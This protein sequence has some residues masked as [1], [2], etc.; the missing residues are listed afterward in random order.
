MKRISSLFIFFILIIYILIAYQNCGSPNPNATKSGSLYPGVYSNSPEQETNDPDITYSNSKYSSRDEAP[1]GKEDWVIFNMDILKK[2][3]EQCHPPKK[4]TMP[5][6]GPQLAKFLPNS[7]S[8]L[9][10]VS[11]SCDPED[12]PLDYYKNSEN[13]TSVNLFKK[14][15]TDGQSST[16]SEDGMKVQIH[17]FSFNSFGKDISWNHLDNASIRAMIESNDHI[18]FEKTARGDHKFIINENRE[19][20]AIHIYIACRFYVSF[21]GETYFSMDKIKEAVVEHLPSMQK[22]ADYADKSG[23]KDSQCEKIEED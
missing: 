16:F 22:I 15:S 9:K 2:I 11:T 23:D 5:L 3:G 4:I 7:I 13:E 10:H 1:P 14:F 6:S 21:I 8:G 18:R 12:W 19:R 17:D 20:P